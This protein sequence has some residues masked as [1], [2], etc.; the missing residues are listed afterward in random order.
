[1]L[2]EVAGLPCR[3]EA[4][5]DGLWLVTVASLSV[6]RRGDLAAAIVEAAGGLVSSAHAEAIAAIDV[7]KPA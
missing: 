4:V 2:T 3:I 7:S 1:L 6:S 5:S